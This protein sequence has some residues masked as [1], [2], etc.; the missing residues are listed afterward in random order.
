MSGLTIELP[1]ATAPAEVR[2]EALA[3][4]A[5][6][7]SGERTELPPGRYWAS[8]VLPDGEVASRSF[9][10]AGDEDLDIRLGEDPAP[11]PARALGILPRIPDPTAPRAFAK[12]WSANDFA[13][14]RM[15]I[16]RPGARSI[17]A[18]DTV[19][20]A[21]DRWHVRL[22]SGV[23]GAPAPGA[24][25]PRLGEPSPSGAVE[26]VF[27]TPPA[28]AALFAQIA[29][30]GTVPLNVAIPVAPGGECRLAVRAGGGGRIEAVA[31]PSPVSAT[32][33]SVGL[34][35]AAGHLRE[36]AG[37]AS[38]AE[39]L[40]AGKVADPIGAT[41]GGYALLRLGR[42]GQ[43]HDWPA[44]LAAWFQWLPDGA[45]VAGE[46]AALRGDPASARE[47]FGEAVRRGVP[48]FTDGLSLVARR[49]AEGL[50]D[51]P[52]ARRLAALAARATIG[53]LTVTVRAF[54]PT[55]PLSSLRTRLQFQ[56]RRGWTTFRNPL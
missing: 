27:T 49:A 31:D 29:R 45:I 40:L 35:L 3:L 25:E 30:A 15:D 18:A 41:M 13:N 20:P 10:L 5:T 7:P 54:D 26:V 46:L 9:V 16:A 23:S 56:A 22:V 4:V 55:D 44:N 52:D 36:A 6:L 39:Q 48:L 47:H 17:A 50:V 32:A 12:R 51:G 38:A 21:T 37:L 34:Y 43:L 33:R 2:D 53:P 28:P 19:A 24:P 42:L 11:A 14:W 8:V 1:E